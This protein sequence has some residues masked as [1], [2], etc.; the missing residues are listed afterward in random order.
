MSMHIPGI[1]G[2][3]EAGHDS[4]ATSTGM[5]NDSRAQITRL[6]SRSMMEELTDADLMQMKKYNSYLSELSSVQEQLF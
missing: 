1:P 4:M 2:I 3:P 5:A 6:H